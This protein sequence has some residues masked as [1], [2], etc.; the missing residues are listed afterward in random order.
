[1]E[2]TTLKDLAAIKAAFKRLA[3]KHDPDRGG[4]EED[5]KA[6]NNAYQAALQY[7]TASAR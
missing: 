5:F 1:L 4:K 6:L 7:H 2:L 3:L